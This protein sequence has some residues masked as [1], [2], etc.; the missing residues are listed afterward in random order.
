M[1]NMGH[2]SVR[3]QTSLTIRVFTQE[4]NTLK[5]IQKITCDFNPQETCA[6]ENL[7]ESKENKILCEQS[8]YILQR[9]DSEKA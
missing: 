9:N 5:I 6:A 3:V 1:R 2:F 8:K 4:T 7:F